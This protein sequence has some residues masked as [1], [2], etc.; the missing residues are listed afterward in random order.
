MPELPEVESTARLLSEVMLKQIVVKITV[1]AKGESHFNVP[2]NQ[3]S[4]KLKGNALLHLDRVGKWLLLD[5]GERAKVLA[6]LRMSGR[7]LVS[8]KVYNHR[9]NRFQLHLDNGKVINYVDQR[10]FGTFHVQ[11]NF[12]DHPTLS[13]LGPD[14][15]SSEFNTQYFREAVKSK[16][17]N[18]YSV[19]LDQRIVA[20][21][22]NIYVNEILHAARIHPLKLASSLTSKEISRI[23]HQT[24]VILTKAIKMNGTTLIDSLYKDPSGSSGEFAKM[25]KVYG[26]KDDPNVKVL[27]V[28]GRSVFVHKNIFNIQ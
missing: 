10:R 5:F 12:S 14:A 8:E 21:L 18:I 16:M 26:K 3:M 1:A 9:H 17:V 2:V 11:H 22:G 13:I 27:K 28:R 4:K 7:F 23:I 6:H 19:M 20:G 15:L 25:L 24:D